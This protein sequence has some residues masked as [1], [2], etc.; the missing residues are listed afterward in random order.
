MSL[1]FQDPPVEQKFRFQVD[2]LDLFLCTPGKDTLR[3][4]ER[5]HD[6]DEAAWD[7]YFNHMA[8]S[9]DLK[10]VEFSIGSREGFHKVADRLWNALSVSHNISCIQLVRC[11]LLAND[12]G[13]LRESGSSLKSLRSINLTGNSLGLR[14]LASVT[15][16]IDGLPSLS[17]LNLSSMDLRFDE[18]IDSIGFY[19][20]LSSATNLRKLD[21]SHNIVSKCAFRPFSLG[22]ATAPSLTHIGMNGVQLG[23]RGVVVLCEEL[24]R[25]PEKGIVALDV[26]ANHIQDVGATALAS[27]VRATPTLKIF[28]YQ[29]NHTKLINF[30]PLCESIILSPSLEQVALESCGLRLDQK[31]LICRMVTHMRSLKELFIDYYTAADKAVPEALCRSFSCEFVGPFH[32][33]RENRLYDYARTKC[34]TNA[35]LLG[36]LACSSDSPVYRSF[37]HSTLFDAHLVPY[38]FKFCIAPKWT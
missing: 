9:K 32:G 34:A 37:F 8:T 20:A 10:T 18:G 38:L 28:L 4:P 31:G 15:E 3:V 19:Q 11:R 35:F 17:S 27:L 1:R 29:F 22:L 33:S 25:Q 7:L 36:D 6:L 16:L 14:G 24:L 2:W 26:Q 21:V 5:V 30:I 23:D 13:R 12:I